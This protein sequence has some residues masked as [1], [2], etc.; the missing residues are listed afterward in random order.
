[1]KYFEFGEILYS[2]AASA[3]FGVIAALFYVILQTFIYTIEHFIFLPKRIFICSKSIAA[4]RSSRH[5]KPDA[6]AVGHGLKL[7]VGDFLYV[8]FY[9]IGTVLLLYLVCD[10]ELRLYPIVTSVLATLLSMK[11]FAKRLRRMIEWLLG[12]LYSC[13]TVAICA[14]IL[15]IRRCA[16][17]VAKLFLPLVHRIKS[18]AVAKKSKNSKKI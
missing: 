12:A 6:S 5:V 8:L 18:Y 10:G 1:M 9:G 2:V 4:I 14:V 17:T 7:A 15:P 13:I 16:F 11:L 3:A